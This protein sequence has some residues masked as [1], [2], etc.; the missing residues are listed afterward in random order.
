MDATLNSHKRFDEYEVDCNECG[1][2]WTD[3][4]DGTPRGV[5]KRC[6]SFVATRRT[7]IPERIKQLEV[8]V[9]TLK[10]VMTGMN[11]I[12]LLHLLTHV[13]EVLK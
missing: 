2:Y 1:R 10:T 12:L 3:Q 7:D 11:F 4:C 13:L 5:E 8:Q 6:T 9:K